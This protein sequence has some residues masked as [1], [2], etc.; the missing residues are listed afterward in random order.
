MKH[1][2]AVLAITLTAIPSVL[3]AQSQPDAETLVIWTRYDLTD[4]TNPNAVNL[5]TKIA[6]FEAET[7]LRVEHEQV[8]W[9]QITL[10]L[11]VAAQTGADVPDVIEV[12]SQ[13]VPSLLEAGALQQLD[14]LLAGSEWLGELSENDRRACVI[15]G[16]RY[17]VAHNVRGGI[18]YYQTSAF[19]GG[20]PQTP[21][22]WLAAAPALSEDDNFF[23]TFYAGRNFVAVEL[24]WYPMIHA[25]GGA[26]FDAEGKPVWATEETAEVVAFVRSLFAG[27]HA[28]Q[29]AVTGDFVDAEV[30][31]INGDSASFRGA[32]WSP[33]FISGLRDGVDA[34][35]V[36]IAGGIDFGSGAATFLMSETW[37]VAQGTANPTGAIA[38]LDAFFAEPGFLATWAQSQYG[39]P[40]HPVALDDPGLQT[41]FFQSIET[42]L[43]EQGV[44]MPYSPYY[45]ESLDELAVAFQE[46][47][48]D[49]ELDALSHLQS[50]Q[51]AVLRR[52]W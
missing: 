15:A 47:L 28:P 33:I 7:G 16:E 8:A 50:A 11:A 12:G 9:D 27:N 24:L 36:S 20:F 22:E 3:T 39:V 37:L 23:T 43:D 32:S 41:P 5:N 1:L 45:R 6:V 46:L 44:Y 49:P 4:E 34:G 40:T 42:V 25:N 35:E 29:L 13:H 14:D 19:P 10:K 38:W 21:D 48:L 2:I 26:I 51:D 18:T 17:C 52:Y 31:W 30:P